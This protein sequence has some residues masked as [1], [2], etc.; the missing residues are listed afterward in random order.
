MQCCLQLA[1]PN[2]PNSLTP[3]VNFCLTIGISQCSIWLQKA[4]SLFSCVTLLYPQVLFFFKSREKNLRFSFTTYYTYPTQIQVIDITTVFL[5]VVGG[6]TFIILVNIQEGNSNLPQ[7]KV[8]AF[9]VFSG[10]N[11]RSLALCT[12]VS[13]L[14]SGNCLKVPF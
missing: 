11:A 10:S 13:S 8:F 1:N 3:S 12:P 9:A 5:W 6:K 4:R 2:S 7:P 14:T